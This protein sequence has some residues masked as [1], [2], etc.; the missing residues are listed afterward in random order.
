MTVASLKDPATAV[1]TARR[2]MLAGTWKTVPKTGDDADKAVYTLRVHTPATLTVLPRVAAAALTRPVPL[3]GCS[4][5]V[6]SF[7]AAASLEADYLEPEPTPT[8]WPTL[9]ACAAAAG[10]A[11]GSPRSP[12]ANAPTSASSSLPGSPR[13]PPAASSAPARTTCWW[14]R[15]AG[16]NPPG[17]LGGRHRPACSGRPLAGNRPR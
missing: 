14:P 11:T 6:A 5:C 3:G 12:P 10:S 8:P 15:S 13:P 2:L 16:W 1:D 9:A 4:W 7:Y 17:H